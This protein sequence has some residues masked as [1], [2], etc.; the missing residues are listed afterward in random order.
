MSTAERTKI[1]EAEE[2]AGMW[3]HRAN[4]AAERGETEKAERHYERAQR[5]LDEANVLRGNGDGS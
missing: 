4:V 5:W 3:L 1:I 2:K